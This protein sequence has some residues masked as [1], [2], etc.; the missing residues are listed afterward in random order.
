MNAG[1]PS[2]DPRTFLHHFRHDLRTPINA[3]LG[4]SEMLLEDADDVDL[5]SK[6][7][8]INTLGK[9]LLQ[10][11][12]RVLHNDAL[13][14]TSLEQLLDTARAGLAGPCQTIIEQCARL[15]GRAPVAD[16]PGSPFCEDLDKIIDASERFCTLL[17]GSQRIQDT[18]RAREEAKSTPLLHGRGSEPGRGMVLAVDDNPLNRDLLARGLERQG[19]AYA[20]AGSG[21]EALGMLAA[22]NFDVVL[23]DIMMPEMDGFE[24]LSRI[25]SD[26]ARKHIPVIMISALDQIES[27][28]RCIEMGAEDYLP[29]PFDPVLLKARVGACLEKK[30]LRDQELEYLRNVAAVTN[31]AA[32]VETG[33]FDPNQLGDVA[34]R[35]D[36]LGQLARVF[37]HMAR[38][39]QARVEKLQMQVQ[40]LKV[41]IDETRK[42]TQ[43]AEITETDYFQELQKKARALRQR[44]H[45]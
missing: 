33:N 25:K 31:A 14:G 32:A 22:G 5:A 8:E 43:V 40:Q 3:I 39:I 4:Y 38:E 29:K 9:Q 45:D 20:L 21:P 1:A 28:V 36:P 27:V 7:R 24:V 19:H 13:E 35:D 12:N 26:P 11:V 37:Q 10:D 42:A 34:R 18:S 30:R 23:L 44:R 15:R 16:A 17:E 6:L 2:D 41:E